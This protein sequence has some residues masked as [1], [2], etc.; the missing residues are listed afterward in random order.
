[1]GMY[2]DKQKLYAD[3]LRELDT[4]T[5]VPMNISA[6]ESR[7]ICDDYIYSA[8][9]S[10]HNIKD[11]DSDELVGFLIIGKEVPEKHPDS[12]RSVAQAYVKPEFRK[13]GLMTAVMSDYMTRHKGVYSLLVIAGN[14]YAAEF[15]RNFFEKEGY[16]SVDLDHSIIKDRDLILYGYA[17]GKGTR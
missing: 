8:K 5:R 13:R 2:E 10:W 1:M 16:H 15:W 3:Y 4:F 6:E 14:T 17:P 9:S 12:I 7:K 11:P